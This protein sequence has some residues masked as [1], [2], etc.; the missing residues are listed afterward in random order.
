MMEEIEIQYDPEPGW[1]AAVAVLAVGGLYTALPAHLTMGPRW[2]IPMVV[3][4]L[5]VPTV[6]SHSVG[7]HRLNAV[8]GFSVTSALTA[9]LIIS[10]VQLIRA[11]PEHKEAPGELLLSAAS[12][13]G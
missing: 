13:W 7:R 1:P 10:L 4:G 9:G 8:L 3:I 6:V 11:L 12:L 2:L 5:L